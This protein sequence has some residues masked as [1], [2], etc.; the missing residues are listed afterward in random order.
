ML[1][2]WKLAPADEPL[3]GPVVYGANDFFIAAEFLTARAA[4]R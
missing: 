4:W 3:F 2:D 1:E